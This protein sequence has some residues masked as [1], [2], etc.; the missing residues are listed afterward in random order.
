MTYYKATMPDGTDFH[1]GTVHYARALETGEVIEHPWPHRD[2]D[3][4]RYFSIATV[5]TDCTGMS[6]PARLFEVEP[7]GDV[8]TPDA[9]GLPNKRACMALRVV[10]ELDALLALGPQGEQI[11]ALIERRRSLTS[12]QIDLLNAAWNATWN[13]AWDAAWDAA[14]ET[15]RDTAWDT[16]WDAAGDAA[17]CPGGPSAGALVVRDLIGQYGFTQEHYDTL[18]GPWRTAIGPIHP[19]DEDIREVTK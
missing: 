8:W 1:T 6:W 18:T 4:S 11:V 13:A 15:A 5:A 12:R 7:V 14:R 17:G 2:G 19:D 16:T 10:R 3:A 9:D